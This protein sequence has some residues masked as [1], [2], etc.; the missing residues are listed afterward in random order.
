MSVCLIK[1]AVFV[2]S[3]HLIERKTNHW[4]VAIRELTAKTL[5]KLTACEPVYMLNKVLPKLLEKTSSIDINQRHG[6]VLAIGEIVLKLKQMENAPNATEIR[7]GEEIKLRVSN[8]IIT[9]QERNQF[10]GKPNFN[11]ENEVNGVKF[12]NLN[13]FQG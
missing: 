8:L 3:D 4:D 9:F 11:E 12:E 1:M 7:I 6:A 13:F 10:R 5:H 2:L